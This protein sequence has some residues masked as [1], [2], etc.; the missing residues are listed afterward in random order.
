MKAEIADE[1]PLEGGPQGTQENTH[2]TGR[3]GAG[4]GRRLLGGLVLGDRNQGS[5]RE[6]TTGITAEGQKAAVGSGNRKVVEM[7]R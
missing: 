6:V 5:R 1:R 3:P 4:V 7:P 2:I